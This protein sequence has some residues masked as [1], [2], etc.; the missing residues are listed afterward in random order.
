MKLADAKVLA[1]RICTVLG[2]F[3]ERVEIAGSIRRGRSEVGDVDIV[4]LPKAVD[5][6]GGLVGTVHWNVSQVWKTLIPRAFKKSWMTVEASGQELLRSSFLDGAFQVDVYRA[7]PETWGVILLV[8]TG[9]KE[10]NVKLCSIA[11]SKGLKLSASHGILDN[12]GIIACRTEEGIFQ[13]LGLKF[14]EPK[15]REVHY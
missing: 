6:P 4:A 7:K 5:L 11:Q 13:A 3:C 8:R 1:D 15:D 2:P 14:I 12:S 9:S 10:H